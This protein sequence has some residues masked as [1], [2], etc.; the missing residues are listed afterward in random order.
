LSTVEYTKVFQGLVNKLTALCGAPFAPLINTTSPSINIRDIVNKGQILYVDL[1]A[2]MYPSSF[3]RISTM[4][5]MDLQSSLTDRYQLKDAKPMFLYMDEFADLVYPQVRALI[6]K[7]REAKVGVTY[8]HQSLGELERHGPAIAKGIFESSSNKVI[9][10]VGSP[11][12]A[13]MLAKLAGTQTVKRDGINYSLQGGIGGMQ[14]S[15]EAKG[16]THVQEEQFLFHPNDLK[17]LGVGEGLV[18]VQRHKGRA[19]YKT[20]LLTAPTDIPPLKDSDLHKPQAGK[21]YNALQLDPGHR[22]TVPDKPAP[23]PLNP[24]ASNALKKLGEKRRFEKS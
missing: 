20:R 7:A 1:A 23:V 3:F 14:G 8:A 13:E 11:E 9:F 24:A 10:R 12:T 6:A 4:L 16:L 17:N 21:A 2:D 5:M 22:L 15:P 19:L 18:I